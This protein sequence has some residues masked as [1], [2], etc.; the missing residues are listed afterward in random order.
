MTIDTFAKYNTVLQVKPVAPL[1]VFLLQTMLCLRQAAVTETGV[2]RWVMLRG[3]RQKCA[4]LG[5]YFYRTCDTWRFFLHRV[6]VLLE[7][8]YVEKYT[9]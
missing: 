5:V 7:C 2:P 6:P 9:F 1:V 3:Q 8:A 4:I